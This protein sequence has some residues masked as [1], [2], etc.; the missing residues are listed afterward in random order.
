LVASN[1]G[2][3]VDHGGWIVVGRVLAE[4]LV[5]PVIIEM[6]HVVMEDGEGVSLVV[7]Q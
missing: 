5:R 2:V 3:E 7:D 4:A 6:T 1:R